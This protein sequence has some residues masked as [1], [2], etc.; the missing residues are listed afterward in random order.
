MTGNAINAFEKLLV[1]P[2]V[3]LI[4]EKN[5][6]GFHGGHARYG[7]GHGGMDSHSFLIR[8]I[9]QEKCLQMPKGKGRI[10]LVNCKPELPQQK[11]SWDPVSSSIMNVMSGHCLTVHKTDEFSSLSM[12][13]CEHA[14][15][16]TWSCDKQGH[17][18]LKSHELYL[19]SQP[20]NK[21]VFLSKDKTN[22]WETELGS[23]ICRPVV[24]PTEHYQH[25]TTESKQEVTTNVYESLLT[26]TTETMRDVPW[27]TYGDEIK[28]RPSMSPG[29]RNKLFLG[30][31]RNLIETDYETEQNA[32]GWHMAMLILCPLAL[33][34]GGVIL[35]ISIRNNKK[36]KLSALPSHSK[37]LLKGGPVYIQ[38][39]ASEIAETPECPGK[40]PNAA[41]LKH[42]EIM[43]E[44]K[45][46]TV[47]PLFDPQQN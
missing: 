25:K 2:R 1:I 12:Q 27:I 33:V 45:D 24:K 32:S 30:A 11:W 39:P 14:E 16:Q 6:T 47:T 44:W 36:R 42:G 4:V 9:F 3:P 46:G 8:N 17:L 22:R 23:P 35:A 13:V 15:H 29:D 10:S 21:K 26:S 43:I 34:L 28:L 41:T 40:D 18:H 7:A 31:Q 37:S 5:F 19:S 38:C 20:G